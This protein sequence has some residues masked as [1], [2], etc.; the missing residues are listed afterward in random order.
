V[1]QANLEA[2]VRRAFARFAL[3]R[4]G[5]TRGPGVMRPIWR[6]RTHVMVE[7]TQPMAGPVDGILFTRSASASQAGT[8]S[9]RRRH[10]W[11]EI[12]WGARGDVT[13]IMGGT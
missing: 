5:D 9:A 8:Q 7:R 3:G 11:D 13:W 1:P 2:N 10:G 12:F 4:L 6:T